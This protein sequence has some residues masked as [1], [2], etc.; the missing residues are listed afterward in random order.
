MSNKDISQKDLLR[1]PSV[2]A[3]LINF[4]L[5]DNKTVIRASQIRYIDLS[6]HFFFDKL[7]RPVFPDVC[8]FVSGS[9]RNLPFILCFENQ[10]R[11]D[12]TMA[13]RNFIY[14]AAVFLWQL[15]QKHSSGFEWT[16]NRFV[17]CVVFTLH[18]GR[19]AWKPKSFRE[20]FQFDSYPCLQPF[21]TDY[22]M[23]VENIACW[24]REKIES[25]RSDFRFIADYCAQMRVSHGKTYEPP[26]T[27]PI[28][29][30]E[31]T[32][33]ALAALSQDPDLKKVFDEYVQQFKT[34][35]QKGAPTM[36]SVIAHIL[37]RGE[38]IGEQ[39]GEQRG[40]KRGRQLGF[41]EAE[42]KFE[43]K[44]HTLTREH[45]E[46]ISTF[47]ILAQKRMVE[48]GLSASE[49]LDQLGYPETI[50]AKVLPFLVN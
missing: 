22:K 17:P 37:Q 25:I 49:A 11:S 8:V 16:K 18:Y 32:L 19:F 23:N 50:R 47:V 1:I 28:E 42:R 21:L 12:S 38:R 3:S 29:H 34:N 14:I 15:R 43:K 7:L 35:E 26:T 6:E 30:V 44:L 46:M 10:T 33:T 24:D 5:Y 39:R 20:L 27:W 13:V 4:L 36:A 9:K 31:Q 2:V 48:Q 41:Q 40:E 45:N